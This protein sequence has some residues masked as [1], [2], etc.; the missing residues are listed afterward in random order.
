MLQIQTEDLKEM[1]AALRVLLERRDEDRVELEEKTLSNVKNLIEPYFEKL[2]QSRLNDR[3]RTYMEIVKTNLYDI[4][5]PFSK[6]LSSALFR[7]T[8]TEIQISNLIKQGKTTKEIAEILVSSGIVWKLPEKC[9]K[10]LL[11]PSRY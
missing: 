2:D 4:I 7:L 3:Q 10:T 1:N 6:N 9:R 8:P 5:S 11:F